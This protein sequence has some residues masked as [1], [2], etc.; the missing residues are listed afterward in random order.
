MHSRNTRCLDDARLHINTTYPQMH[1]ANNSNPEE[2]GS[3]THLVKD[4]WERLTSS[5]NRLELAV[6]EA[7]QTQLQK[8]PSTTYTLLAAWPGGCLLIWESV[9]QT[10]SILGVCL[11]PYKVYQRAK[12]G[13]PYPLSWRK[14]L[15]T[16]ADSEDTLDAP[17]VNRKPNK[18]WLYASLAVIGI[19]VVILVRL[20]S[21]AFALCLAAGH[22]LAGVGALCAQL[23][24]VFWKPER[25]ERYRHHG[26]PAKLSV[27]ERILAHGK[28]IYWLFALVV[29][30]MICLLHAAVTTRAAALQTDLIITMLCTLLLSIAVARLAIGWTDPA[31]EAA[32]VTDD[33]DQVQLVKL[34]V[35]KCVPR[36]LETGF[37]NVWAIMFGS[38]RR[39]LTLT[40]PITMTAS[41]IALGLYAPDIHMSLT[42]HPV[43]YILLFSGIIATTAVC[44]TWATEYFAPAQPLT[45]PLPASPDASLQPTP[46]QAVTPMSSPDQTKQASLST[47]P[48]IE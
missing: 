1:M 15:L 46:Y 17:L 26:H 42:L 21:A 44:A 45:I 43:P 32:F 18:P 5:M 37:K 30:G 7:Y 25:G 38:T 47:S 3:T 10:L 24:G 31:A 41:L 34:L 13:Q 40:L 22:F 27:D 4:F 8:Y 39:F 9:K 14:A 35:L 6:L 23:L 33:S 29:T 12:S 20:L 19:P 16:T 28:R 2:A 36:P 11:Y 48:T